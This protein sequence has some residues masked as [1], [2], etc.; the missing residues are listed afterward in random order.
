MSKISFKN[1]FAPKQGAII[2]RRQIEDFYYKKYF[3]LWLDSVEWTGIDYQEKAF[4]MRQFWAEGRVGAIKLKGSEGAENYPNGKAIFVPFAPMQYNIYRFPTMAN[5]IKL[6]G[7]SF[8]PDKPLAV[9][10]E[11]VIGWANVAHDPVARMIAPF[12]ERIVDTQMVIRMNL[13][14]QK[15][16]WLVAITP[17]TEAKMRKLYDALESDD[18]TLFIDLEE[19][20]K[21]KALLSGA[22]YIIDKLHEYIKATENDIREYLGLYN[23][24]FG[25]KKEHLITSEVES[26]D[27][28]TQASGSCFIDTIKDWCERVTRIL[29]IPI[30]AELKAERLAR[31]KEEREREMMKEQESE[32]NED[33]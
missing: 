7:V 15:M 13:K 22:P 20:D 2:N 29:G 31:E 9:D 19:A 3:S 28:V 30:S 33:E 24:G 23:L 18:P 21:A 5:A 11:I 8:I 6:K 27:E 4:I 25:E 1:H 12:V 32:G 17:E 14:A 26:N 10:K 16:P